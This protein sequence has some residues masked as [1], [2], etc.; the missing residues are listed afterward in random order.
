M[1]S[2]G[3]DREDCSAARS[4]AR[5]RS[6]LREPFPSPAI[7]TLV[8]RPRASAPGSVETQPSAPGS[9][10]DPFDRATHR[11]REAVAVAD[12]AAAPAGAPALRAAAVPS[13]SPAH[14]AARASGDSDPPAAGPAPSADS[15]PAA[16]RAAAGFPAAAG[17]L[18]ASDS[19]SYP[20]PA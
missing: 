6:G 10:A 14:S 2:F 16:S 11:R 4:P 19:D 3:T 9:R 17:R 8:E 13:P 12:R 18:V 5:P 20:D 15:A 7:P 1:R